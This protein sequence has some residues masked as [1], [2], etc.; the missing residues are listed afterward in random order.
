MR[1]FIK[2]QT[3]AKGALAAVI[4]LAVIVVTVVL[5]ILLNGDNKKYSGSVR[6]ENA[7]KK[8]GWRSVIQHSSESKY[9]RCLFLLSLLLL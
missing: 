9:S 3:V 8:N 7:G 1:H 6:K 5:V 4:I 2:P